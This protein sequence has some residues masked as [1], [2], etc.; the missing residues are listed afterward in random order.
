[1]QQ[2]GTGPDFWRRAS[3]SPAPRTALTVPP[4]P[5]R[6]SR[7]SAQFIL[8]RFAIPAAALGV[9]VFFLVAGSGAR[10]RAPTP[11]LPEIERLA[12]MV[13][14]DLQQVSVSGHR[15]TPDGDIFDAVDLA[16][17]RTM[18]SFDSRAARQRLERLPWIERASIERIIP[19]RLEITVVER[20]PF[21]VWL[22][23]SRAFL[24]DRSGKVLTAIAR[25]ALPEL[26]RVAGEGAPTESS[27]LNALLASHQGL[28]EQIRLAERVGGRR[29][30]L[31]LADGGAVELPAWGEREALIRA[32]ALMRGGMARGSEIDLRVEG[33]ALLR[34]PRGPQDRNERVTAAEDAAGRS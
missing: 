17:A 3:Q 5:Q 8:S 15:F 1:M 10:G 6:H 32:V 24:I 29:W 23:E 18:L 33:Q 7:E 12:G 31:H 25:D 2:V 22:V 19:D 16:H 27:A 9:I 4:T 11:I 30:R 26:P 20:A 28:L 21:A 14:V 13:G 34:K